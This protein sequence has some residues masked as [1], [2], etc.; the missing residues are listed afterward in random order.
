MIFLRRRGRRFKF[1]EFAEGKL[2][3]LSDD[4]RS[5]QPRQGL[6]RASRGSFADAYA[7]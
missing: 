4:L 1:A 3:L 7:D 2:A 6:C 5:Y